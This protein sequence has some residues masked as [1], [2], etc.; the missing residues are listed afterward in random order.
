MMNK[1]IAEGTHK[2]TIRVGLLLL[3]DI[4]LINL[5]SFL[6]LWVRLDFSVERMFAEGYVNSLCW[7]SA[8]G[9]FVILGLLAAMKLYNSLWIYASVEELLR[10]VGVGAMVS[11]LEMAAILV[12]IVSLPRSFPLLHG[13]FFVA[14]MGVSRFAY[15]ASR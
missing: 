5:A 2:R 6:A 8:A 4:L 15:R 12:G 7:L 14:L 10:I 3:E 11:V 13:M 1:K 9:T